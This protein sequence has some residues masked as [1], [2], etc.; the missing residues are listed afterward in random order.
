MVVVLGA[1]IA[2]VVTVVGVQRKVSGTCSYRAAKEI[3]ARC[4]G[5]SEP[6]TT[7][8]TAEPTGSKRVRATLSGHF[9]IF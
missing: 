8:E 7:D 1:S 5:V 3:P 9:L 2:Q 6:W 4:D